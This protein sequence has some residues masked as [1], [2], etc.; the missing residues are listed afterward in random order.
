[1]TMTPHNAYFRERPTEVVLP[2]GWLVR[3]AEVSVELLDPV[4]ARV[5]ALTGSTRPALTVEYA[6]RGLDRGGGVSRW[7]AVAIGRADPGAPLGVSFTGR[8]SRSRQR[9]QT[10]CSLRTFAAPVVIGGLWVAAVPGLQVAVTCDQG[11][12]QFVR[13]VVPLPGRRPPDTVGPEDAAA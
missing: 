8:M 13:S 2:G 9:D 5:A 11:G 12:R 4:G 1:M 6:W 10:A 7:W 3:H